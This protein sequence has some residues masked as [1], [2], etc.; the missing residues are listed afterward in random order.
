MSHL[1][2]R[3]HMICLTPKIRN[4][5]NNFINEM[6]LNV[7]PWESHYYLNTHFIVIWKE[8]CTRVYFFSGTGTLMSFFSSPRWLGNSSASLWL[9]AACVFM[10][11]L[12]AS[13]LWLDPCIIVIISLFTLSA[14]CSC[15]WGLVLTS[16]FSLSPTLSLCLEASA[17]FFD[18]IYIFFLKME[19]SFFF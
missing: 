8:N 4:R 16:S 11:S 2:R 1:N 9:R 10:A 5:N 7:P 13:Y 14:Q 18:P 12:L 17:S 15:T 6:F 19:Q 3:R